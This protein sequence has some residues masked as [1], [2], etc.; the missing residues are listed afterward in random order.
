[1]RNPVTDVAGHL[2]WTDYGTVWATWRITPL[3]Y[4]RRPVKD[5][6]AVRDLH[7]LLFRS[8]DGEALALGVAVALD[9]VA[10]VERQIAGLDLD[11]CPGLVAEAEANL[12]RLE[13]L[14]LGERAYFLSIPM[15]NH[16]RTRWDAKVRAALGTVQD[17]ADLPRAHPTPEQIHQRQVQAAQLEA[18]IPS[19]FKARPASA[20]ELIWLSAHAARRGM[21]DFPP[22]EPGSADE[23]MFLRTGAAFPEPVFDE[24]AWSD[25]DVAGLASR[26]RNPLARKVL[27]VTDPR[28]ADLGQPASYQCPMVIADTPV[29]GLAWPGSELLARLDDLTQ[30][31]DWAIRLKVN[32][33]DKVMRDNRKALRELNDQFDQRS[34]EATLGRTDMDLAADLLAD[35]QSI[36]SADRLEVEVEHT[37]IVTVS[38]VDAAGAMQR[39]KSLATDMG[40]SDF[41]LE[42]PVGA[43]TDLWWATQIGAPSSRT[44]SSYGQ[45]TTSGDLSAL[46]PFVSTHLGGRRGHPWALNTSS[47]RTSIIHLNPGGYPELDKSGSVCFVGENGAGKSTALKTL[48]GSIVDEGG[49]LLAIDKSSEGEWATFAASLTASNPDSTTSADGLV[50]PA[51]PVIVDPED[52]RWSMDPLRCLGVDDGA[53]VLQS[54]FSQLLNLAAQEPD[55]VTLAHVLHPVYLRTHAI[56]STQEVMEHLEGA[57]AEL[58]EGPG[59]GRRMRTFA[60][61]PLGRLVL[62]DTLPP[63]DGTADVI[64]WRTNGMEQPT[65][66]EIA[67]HHLFRALSPSKVFGRAYYRL[68]ISTARR[69]AFADTSRVSALACDEAYDICENP[70]NSLDLEHF[71][72][73]GRRPKA[74]LLL[75]SHNPEHDFGSETMR[76]LIPTRVVMRHTSDPLARISIAW[77]GVSAD[78][79]EFE[80][81]VEEL[82][83]HTSPALPD[84]GVLP[85]RRG[86]CFV[87]DAFGGIGSAQIL[88]SA[89]PARAAAAQTTPPQ[90]KTSTASS[91]ARSRA[92]TGAAQ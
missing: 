29:A 9:P 41:K 33:R 68:L 6:R 31:A 44:V 5:K 42:R 28:A 60:N 32:P 12:D 15:A 27:K 50:G 37:I 80:T 77:L 38:D 76:E 78:D 87:R 72:R 17:L 13:T 14:V 35:Y 22:P 63:V 70:E 7:R 11:Q 83:F 39:A 75:G 43:L 4:G 48:A 40:N 18:L 52:L 2:S 26:V 65:T 54:F 45:V 59:L 89:R 21:L 88:L 8:L 46:V 86:E 1:M 82:R 56:T 71:V 79:P 49:Q 81:M 61:T 85:H 24:G 34:D 58:P 67:N 84:V 62:E 66:Q 69:W 30:D 92:T 57:G 16:G 10:V 36:F 91:S 73:Q 55:G 53:P 74:L 90:S 51:G 20:G 19:P 47:A 25:V 64:V 23:S 3:A